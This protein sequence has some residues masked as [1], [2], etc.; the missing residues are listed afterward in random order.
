[1]LD[2]DEEEGSDDQDGAGEADEDAS[3]SSSEEDDTEKDADYKGAG[4]AAAAKTK[5]KATSASVEPLQP[6]RPGTKDSPRIIPSIASASSTPAAKKAK[7]SSGSAA[8]KATSKGPEKGKGKEKENKV[9]KP[10]VEIKKGKFEV[11]QKPLKTDFAQSYTTGAFELFCLHCSPLPSGAAGML[12][13]ARRT[14]SCTPSSPGRSGGSRMT[15]SRKC[16]STRKS[17][18]ASSPSSF[19]NRTCRIPRAHSVPALATRLFVI[20][21]NSGR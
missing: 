14:Q 17:T 11:R 4:K 15:I 8:T 21:F 10:L 19:T 16:L 18:M 9:E 7:T 2:D 5:R 6:G 20:W 13:A 1:M 12:T 3:S